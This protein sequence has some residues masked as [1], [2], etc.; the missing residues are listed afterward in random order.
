MRIVE[1]GKHKYCEQYNKVVYSMEVFSSTNSNRTQANVESA[2]GSL[3]SRKD[4]GHLSRI[5]ILLTVMLVASMV[6]IIVFVAKKKEDTTGIS[7][8]KNNILTPPTFLA[9]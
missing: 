7:L 6:F 5:L 1:L 9:K 8:V 3:D 4:L 2:R